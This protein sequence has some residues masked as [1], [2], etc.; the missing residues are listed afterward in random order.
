MTQCTETQQERTRG[1]IAVIDPILREKV[2][3]AKATLQA[4]GERDREY[5]REQ[6]AAD[7]PPPPPANPNRVLQNQS[8][9][10]RL[11]AL[12]AE[13]PGFA[14]GLAIVPH[15]VDWTQLYNDVHARAEELGLLD[16]DAQAE[17]TELGYE[18]L[19][20]FIRGWVHGV[21]AHWRHD[22]QMNRAEWER[23]GAQ[24]PPAVPTGQE[25][26]S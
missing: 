6:R 14:Q 13:L 23:G 2:E 22:V 10:A 25:A 11:K 20:D 7:A 21:R 4:M 5:Q 1:C 18:S 12:R 24:S 8:V 15:G 17:L 3:R 26:A 16:A 19:T 9:G